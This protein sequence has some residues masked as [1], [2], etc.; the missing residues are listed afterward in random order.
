MLNPDLL[1]KMK[2]Y[3]DFLDRAIAE[4]GGDT[5]SGAAARQRLAAMPLRASD[6]REIGPRQPLA[7]A[8]YPFAEAAE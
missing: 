2:A 5:P 4:L 6:L 7:T 8:N 3:G 1:A